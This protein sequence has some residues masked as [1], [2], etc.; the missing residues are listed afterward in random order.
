MN[1]AEEKRVEK[2][3]ILFPKPNY[4]VCKYNPKED[5]I[6]MIILVNGAYEPKLSQRFIEVTNDFGAKRK[7]VSGQPKDNFCISAK[8][9]E[10]E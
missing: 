3:E 9:L 10:V 8:M 6:S 1:L 7:N 4:V 2:N 5:W